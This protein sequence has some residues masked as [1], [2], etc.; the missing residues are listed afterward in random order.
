MRPPE[1]VLKYYGTWPDADH[2]REV[3][4]I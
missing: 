1:H 3:I 2:N 4:R